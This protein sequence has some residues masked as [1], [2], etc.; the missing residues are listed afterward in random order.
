MKNCCGVQQGDPLGPLSFTITETNGP[1]CGLLL[2]R[3]TSLVYIPQDETSSPSDLLP[4]IPTTSEDF[5]H[6]GSPVAPPSFCVQ[7]LH[8]HLEK[9][10]QAPNAL[11]L[12]ED[13]KL[14]TTLLRSGLL[15]PKF[16]FILRTCLPDYISNA[17]KE[18][19]SMIRDCLEH[20][21]GRPISSWSLLK[22]SLPSSCGGI[23]LHS[24][25]LHSP[26]AYL[27]SIIGG[28]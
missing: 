14:Q 24:V 25:S 27:T 3:S 1:S 6:L 28:Q 23:N 4:D 18:F 17:T 19:N 26:A 12:L 10:K 2:N 8:S 15:L 5:V 16:F 13:S 20:I 7:I 21:I 22:V 9:L 11:P